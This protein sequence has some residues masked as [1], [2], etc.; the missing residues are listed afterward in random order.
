MNSAPVLIITYLNNNKK[1]AT[2][3]TVFPF[4]ISF[5][6]F[7]LLLPKYYY[8]HRV[9][10]A[11]VQGHKK[12]KCISLF[13]TTTTKKKTVNNRMEKWAG[14]FKLGRKLVNKAEI[15]L[16]SK[17]TARIWWKEKQN[18]R[19]Y[20]WAIFYMVETCLVYTRKSTAISLYILSSKEFNCSEWRISC[21]FHGLRAWQFVCVYIHYWG[22]K[23][24]GCNISVHRAHSV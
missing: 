12:W 4:L 20:N 11:R 14:L 24:G 6:F 13:T 2:H 3:R 18:K 5:F 1:N 8:S 10:V 15:F 9:C 17:L 19:L 7:T 16:P 22:M 21:Y 23:K